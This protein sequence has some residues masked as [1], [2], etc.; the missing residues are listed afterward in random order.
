MEYKWFA[1]N[2]LHPNGTKLFDKCD[3]L[4]YNT[5]AAQY[6][7]LSSKGKGEY[8]G[9]DEF[10]FQ[11]SGISLTPLNKNYQKLIAE[12]S[13]RVNDQAQPETLVI[14]NFVDNKTIIDLLA[15]IENEEYIKALYKK[16]KLKVSSGINTQDANLLLEC[17]RQGR[18][19]LEAGQKADILAKPLIDFYAA[20]AF[21]YALI[22]I[23]SPLH[24]SINSLK[25]SHGHAYNHLNGTVDF[26]GDIPSGTFLDLLCA[27]PV[28]QI[29]TGNV[30][31]KYSILDSVNF[32]QNNSISLSLLTLLSMVP[33]LTGYYKQ[34]D[35]EHTSVHKLNIDTSIINSKIQYN[36]Y[37]GDGISKPNKEK[38]CKCFNTNEEHIKDDQG[39]YKVSIEADE[40]SSI[41]PIIYRDVRGNLW[42]VESPIDGLYLPEICLHFLI[43]SAL[44]NIMRYSPHEWSMILNNKVSPQFSLLINRYISVF[45]T[46]Y[47]MILVNHLTDYSLRM[48]S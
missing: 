10:I 25:G 5:F 31:I 8:K 48:G 33:E 3:L 24:K 45:E 34:V 18:S 9:K 32:V 14:D 17:L 19:L 37:I 40:V 12:T 30:D 47:P 36:F 29:H 23:N 39:G 16:K 11:K 20:T 6:D 42:Y 28:A 13:E 38:I 4:Q 43:I 46:K 44:C 26:G 41:S 22:V 15:S 2:K 1:T 21:A 35:K 27:F 7:A